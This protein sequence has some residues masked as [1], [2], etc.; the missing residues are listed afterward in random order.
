MSGIESTQTL[1]ADPQV[2][3]SILDPAMG[4]I[5]AHCQSPGSVEA[6]HV[7]ILKQW[8]LSP[9]VDTR[10]RAFAKRLPQSE[11]QI[12]LFKQLK[13]WVEAGKVDAVIAEG[14]SGE[15]TEKSGF[16]VNGWT[17]GDLAK[18]SSEKDFDQI[19]V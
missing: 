17:V 4:K 19:T 2:V 18:L 14:C 3:T 16:R 6:K 9:G 1:A 15:L 8:H 7:L 12:A 10:D 11:N 5:V 13:T